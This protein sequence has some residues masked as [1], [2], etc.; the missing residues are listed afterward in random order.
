MVFNAASQ[1][2]EDKF[3]PDIR[4]GAARGSGEWKINEEN[5]KVITPPSLGQSGFIQSLSICQK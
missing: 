5:P 3:D 4:R 2:S 1:Q